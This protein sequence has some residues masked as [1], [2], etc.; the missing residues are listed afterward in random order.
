MIFDDTYIKVLYYSMEPPVWH[1][2]VITAAKIV[3]KLAIPLNMWVS[4]HRFTVTFP[5][6]CGTFPKFGDLCLSPCSVNAHFRW[7]TSMSRVCTTRAV[8]TRSTSAARLGRLVLYRSS[9]LLLAKVR[10][11]APASRSA[12]RAVAPSLSLLRILEIDLVAPTPTPH[13]PHPH[14]RVQILR[15]KTHKKHGKG[16]KESQCRRPRVPTS[17]T[18]MGILFYK[19]IT[20]VLYLNV[21]DPF[22]LDGKTLKGFASLFN[23]P[24]SI[25][26]YTI[27][28]SVW[29]LV[30]TWAGFI[31]NINLD[32]GVNKIVFQIGKGIF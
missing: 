29:G 14:H 7:W 30:T 10:S 5:Y 28:R 3:S 6:L 18:C 15:T 20:Q 26:V 19:E 11:S 23:L 16:K 25:P 2:Y 17:V 8:D 24:R 21:F 12:W 13:I 31:G 9:I 27:D 22:C 4:D 32:K 1:R